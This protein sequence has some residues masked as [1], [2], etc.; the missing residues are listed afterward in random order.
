MMMVTPFNQIKKIKIIRSNKIN[1]IKLQ[2]SQKTI[3]LIL[4]KNKLRKYK[5]KSNQ[6]S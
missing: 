2:V 1:T 3:K 4:K 6:V 5:N